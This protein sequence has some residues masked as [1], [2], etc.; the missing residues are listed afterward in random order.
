MTSDHKVAPVYEPTSAERLE[1]HQYCLQLGFA[2]LN[3]MEVNGR[4]PPQ[5]VCDKNGMPLLSWRVVILPYLSREDLFKRFRLDEPWDSEN[6]ASLLTEMPSVFS[7]RLRRGQ[8]KTE[9]CFQVFVGPQT[10][11][12][13]CIGHRKPI[14]ANT[15]LIVEAAEMVPWTK[16]ADLVVRDGEPLPPLGLTKQNFVAWFADGTVHT[17]AK[18]VSDD[19]I[20]SQLS[21][22]KLPSGDATRQGIPGPSARQ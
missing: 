5:A 22:W 14:D 10:A 16:P 13:T 19:I 3:Y 17:V 12:N 7:T 9:T 4:L 21:P 11:F 8:S 15:I 2:M 20:R 1:A 18:P 6:N